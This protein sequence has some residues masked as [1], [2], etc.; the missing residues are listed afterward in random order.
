MVIIT[1]IL[2]IKN[3]VLRTEKKIAATALATILLISGVVHQTAI[4]ASV[5]GLSDTM[6]RL[7][8]GET[9]NHAITLTLPATFDWDS[10][11]NND[12]IIFN[13]PEASTDFVQ[14][15]TWVAADFTASD[16]TGSLTVGAVTA[17]AGSLTYPA[18]TGAVVVGVDTTNLLFGFRRCTGGNTAGTAIT[19]NI[20]GTSTGT[21]ILTN[22]SAIGSKTVDVSVTDEGVASTHSGSFA[23]AL[24]QDDQVT[25]TAAISPS[26]IFD[27]DSGTAQNANNDGPHTIALGT[28]TSGALTTSDQSAIK[29]LFIDLSTNAFSGA[30]VTILGSHSTGAL[31]SASTGGDIDG[32][33]TEQTIAAGTEDFGICI[34][35]VTQTSGATLT[36]GT[37]YDAANCNAT[38]TGTQTV[39]SPT[40]TASNLLTSSAPIDGGRAEVLFKAAISPITP[41]ANDYTG[42]MTL[43][44]TGTF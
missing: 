31:T 23:I 8:I 15:G 1:I 25:T 5:T 26:I 27:L 10:T 28:L 37:S 4:A 39:T 9:A 13:F 36:K 12:D 3:A 40:T 7:K 20:L 38:N 18:C 2:M 42:T 6:T 24:T 21:G 32:A 33:G 17:S 11:G 35:S 30:T 34:E 29:S 16:S 14:S 43:I 19:L 22:G 44:A 41:A